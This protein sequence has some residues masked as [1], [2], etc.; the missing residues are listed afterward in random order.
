MSVLTRGADTTKMDAS[1]TEAEQLRHKQN[2]LLKLMNTEVVF[3]HIE[4]CAGSSLRSMFHTY[5]NQIFTPSEIFITYDTSTLPDFSRNSLDDITKL[6]DLRNIKVILSH[7]SVT[8]LYNQ[9]K[10]KITCIRNPFD[11]IISHYYYF[12]Y[13]TTKIHMYDLEY[14][15]LR[16]YFYEYGS[17]ICSRMGC[18]DNNNHTTIASIRNSIRSMDF[19]LIVEQ[20]DKDIEVLNKELNK[21]Y[22]I[23][24][25]IIP[26]ILNTTPYDYSIHKKKIKDILKTIT[27][28]DD[29]FYN[30]VLLMRKNKQRLL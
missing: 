3:Y 25:K 27:T 28:D 13:N 14:S 22:N 30:E 7:T 21:K 15:K 6:I 4:K 11:R 18:L 10:L 1:L 19:I 2:T 16:K 17:L 26:E 29:L 8:D 9:P 24:Y 12:D 20:I 5:F 23:N